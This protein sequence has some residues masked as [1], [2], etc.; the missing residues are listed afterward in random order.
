LVV[1]DCDFE[2]RQGGKQHNGS[3][4]RAEARSP[5]FRERP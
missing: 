3:G 1:H 4:D 5:R 2:P